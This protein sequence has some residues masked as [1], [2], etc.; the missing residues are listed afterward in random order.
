MTGSRFAIE[1][2]SGAVTKGRQHLLFKRTDELRFV[3]QALADLNDSAVSIRE[4]SQLSD[5]LVTLSIWI[6]SQEERIINFV[7]EPALQATQPG[8]LTDILLQNCIDFGCLSGE[9]T[10]EALNNPQK[11]YE[12]LI[13]SRA[14]SSKE[15]WAVKIE[16]AR[17]S[18]VGE[19][20]TLMR[21][22]N[23]GDAVHICRSELLQLLNRPQGAST[24]VR[25]LDAA[26]AFKRLEQ[27]DSEDLEVD[28]SF[29]ATGY[30]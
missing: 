20:S 30:Q 9:L 14:R 23:T 24:N 28:S 15:N 10:A 16:Q 6:R 17:E 18:H 22:V 1:D 25:F 29:R 2:Q 19:W 3:L 7:R 8:L 27:F 13:A 21:N 5:H 26:T 4:P 11:L 12:H